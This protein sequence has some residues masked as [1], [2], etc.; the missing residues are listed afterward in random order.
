MSKYV[1]N[2]S[3][4]DPWLIDESGQTWTLGKNATITVED[5]TAIDVGVA[6]DDSTIKLKG[7]LLVGGGSGIGVEMDGEETTLKIAKSSEVDANVGILSDSVNGFVKN[8]GNIAG[9]Q[10]GAVL[11]TPTELVNSGKISGSVGIGTAS[12]S[13]IHNLEG[14][15]IDGDD[16]GIYVVDDEPTLIENHGKIRADGYAVVVSDG[17]ASTGSV[18]INTGKIVGDVLFGAGSDW[19]DSRTGRING[20]VDGGNGDDTYIVGRRS[21]QLSEK[22]DNGWDEVRSSRSVTLE[23]NFEGISLLGKK[24]VDATGNAARNEIFGNAGDNVIRG[25][26]GND[27]LGGGKGDDQLFGGADNDEFVFRDGDG[28]DRVMDF[29]PGQDQIALLEF[30]F[31]TFDEIAPLMSQHGADTWISLGQG[32]RLILEN[33]DIGDLTEDMFKFNDTVTVLV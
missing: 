3:S 29:E 16:Y 14:G 9:G 17:E 8:A 30:G 22:Y 32:D 7:D 4:T 6:F 18:L 2:E 31:D 24:S 19:I 25:E 27:Y 11:D 13:E 33:V 12:G 1:K 15:L 10:Y 21:G 28:H 26:D 20:M 23:A 5:Q